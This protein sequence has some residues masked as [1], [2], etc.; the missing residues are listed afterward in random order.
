[1]DKLKETLFFIYKSL[2]DWLYLALEE[3]ILGWY[4]GSIQFDINRILDTFKKSC[5]QNI[6]LIPI[7]TYR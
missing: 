1:L 3:M 4:N 2:K 5:P 7:F 6:D